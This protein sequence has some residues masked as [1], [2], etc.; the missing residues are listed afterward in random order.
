MQ[1]RFRP[2]YSTQYDLVSKNLYELFVKVAKTQKLG[3][4]QLSLVKPISRRV[5]ETVSR[6][7]DT[8]V[9]IDVRSHNR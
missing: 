7:R 5:S 8:K 6:N 4:V 1:E 9:F 2:H 3:Y